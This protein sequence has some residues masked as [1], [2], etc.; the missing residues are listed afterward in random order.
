MIFIAERRFLM[1]LYV[2]VSFDVGISMDL[3]PTSPT[4]APRG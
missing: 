2:R 4:V 3:H 1:I